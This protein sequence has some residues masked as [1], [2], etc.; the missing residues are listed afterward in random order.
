LPNG[1]ITTYSHDAAGRL[2]LINHTAAGQTL[3][4]FD[5]TYD[6]IGNRIEVVETFAYLEYHQ[7]YLPLIANEA[8]IAASASK[9]DINLLGTPDSPTQDELQAPIRAQY[10][11]LSQTITFSYD[12]LYR[13]T[14]ADYSSGEYFHYT[15]DEVGNRLTQETHEGANI[16]TYDIANH[17]I[18]VDGVEYTW[19]V[20]GNLLDDGVSTYT[21][22]HANRLTSVVQ[23]SDTYNF[24]YNG[25]GD[26]L[27]QTVN[28]IPTNYTLDLNIGLT[29]VLDDGESNYLY[30]LRRIGEQQPEGWAYHMP[31]AL[32]SVRQLTDASVSVT[33]TQSYEPFGSVMTSIGLGETNYSFTGEWADG[34]GLVHLRARYFAPMQG[35]FLSR[36][37][38]NGNSNVPMS[39]NAWLYVY[40][41]PVNF[42]DPSG[43]IPRPWHPPIPTCAHCYLIED[44]EARRICLEECL[45]GLLDSQDDEYSLLPEGDIP[46]RAYKRLM[47]PMYEN[48]WWRELDDSTL[49]FF[50]VTGYLEMGPLTRMGGGDAAIAAAT[51]AFARRFYYQ[52]PSGCGIEGG[53]ID[54]EFKWIMKYAQSF[55]S[56][57][58]TMNASLTNLHYGSYS[59]AIKF[60]ENILKPKDTSWKIVNW[61]RPWGWFNTQTPDESKYF[62]K[63]WD[64]NGDTSRI[65]V[66]WLM[67]SEN[68]KDFCVLTRNQEKEHCEDESKGNLCGGPP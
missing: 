45:C 64:H 57:A 7:L 21:Y 16:Y 17:L 53:V 56:L 40:A 24:A 36:D 22:D 12:P 39:F 61:N 10:G 68:K 15:Y 44:H 20:N 43:S 55:R 8:S 5:Y 2:L 9:G 23:G 34:T 19:D 32:N 37:T 48:Q 59:Y 58:N 35:R 65:G 46:E 42:S 25:L 52:C 49:M 67:E 18:E 29:Q 63:L 11:L 14:A 31:D 28:G 66:Y 6:G 13:L 27:Q 54:K 41:N 62:R 30:G 4:S 51:E 3:S 50:A 33:L 38:W 60:A 47:D 1:V 26:R